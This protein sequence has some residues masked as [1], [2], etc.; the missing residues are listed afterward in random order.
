M[1]AEAE[2]L[3]DPLVQFANAVAG[4][5]RP[6]RRQGVD[7]ERMIAE[8]QAGLAA[9]EAGRAERAKRNSKVARAAYRQ[10]EAT[11][12]KWRAEQDQAEADHGPSLLVAASMGADPAPWRIY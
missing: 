3:R 11:R 7:A 12:A 8:G 1:K 5:G 6:E 10:Y 4:L 9:I 2:R